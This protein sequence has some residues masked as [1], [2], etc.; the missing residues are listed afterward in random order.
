MDRGGGGGGGGGG[1]G[2]NDGNLRFET[3]EFRVDDA[4]GS[5]FF[6]FGRGKGALGGRQ[7]GWVC[8]MG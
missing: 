4:V 3:G 2:S 6:F 1:V 8:S 5:G 7:L